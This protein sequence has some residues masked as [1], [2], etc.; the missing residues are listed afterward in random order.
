MAIMLRKI[1]RLLKFRI[2][3]STYS[4]HSEKIISNHP[5]S[6][7]AKLISLFL[8]IVYSFGIT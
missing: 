8:A 7:G 4:D 2:T 5:F 3:S 6:A 1:A